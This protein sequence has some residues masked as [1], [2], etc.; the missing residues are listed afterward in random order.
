MCRCMLA[1]DACLA[2]SLQAAVLGFVGSPWTLATYLIEGGS[3]PLYKKIK[4]MTAAAPDVLSALLQHLAVQ[5]AEY[6]CF[7]AR[8]HS[9]PV[10]S[11][12]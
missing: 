4:A 6:M 9:G 3:T 8:R 10:V 2:P 12:R 1:L 11:T 7:Q 5:I